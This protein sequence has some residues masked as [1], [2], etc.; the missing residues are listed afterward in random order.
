MEANGL[1]DVETY[2]CYTYQNKFIN[3]DI[4]DLPVFDLMKIKS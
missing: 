1:L 4:L 2:F 3:G